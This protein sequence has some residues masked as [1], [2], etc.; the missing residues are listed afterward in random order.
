MTCAGKAAA[1]ILASDVT[2]RKEEEGYKESNGLTG[3]TPSK[4][5]RPDR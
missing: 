5:G 1:L 2:R 4:F 3:A